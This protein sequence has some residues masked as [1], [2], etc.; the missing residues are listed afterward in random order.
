MT[1]A[2]VKSL[3]PRGL[4]SP[5]GQ[6]VPMVL[7]CHQ[8]THLSPALHAS[9]TELNEWPKSHECSTALRTQ[10]LILVFPQQFVLAQVQSRELQQVRLSGL[11]L[12]RHV[13]VGRS[14]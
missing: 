7:H 3:A 6:R 13:N 10:E 4:D 5:V 1:R 9:R 11:V 8:S 12:E 2:D 14:R